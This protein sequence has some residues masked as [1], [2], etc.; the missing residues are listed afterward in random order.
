MP[1]LLGRLS[2]RIVCPLAKL[3]LAFPPLLTA[4]VHVQLWPTTALPLTLLVFVAVRSGK[5]WIVTAAVAVPLSTVAL[6]P[7]LLQVL[8]FVKV[9]VA[10]PLL[11]IVVC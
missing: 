2:A 10:W 4:I 9:A 3:A 1:A 8:L 7:P 6:A 11:W 5:H